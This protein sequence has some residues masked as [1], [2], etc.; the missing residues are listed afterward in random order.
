MQGSET[1]E[2]V[3]QR[4]HADVAAGQV[5]E[6]KAINHYNTIIQTTDGVDPVRQDMITTILADEQN[7]LRTFEGFLRE[8]ERNH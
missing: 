4:L 6:G 8:F 3:V 7:H 5:F 1:D 2:T